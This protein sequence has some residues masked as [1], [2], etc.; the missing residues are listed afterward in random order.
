MASHR[1]PS[2]DCHG[3]RGDAEGAVAGP[4]A[5][6]APHQ[7]SSSSRANS[8]AS[9]GT[10]SSAVSPM[11]MDFTGTF[12]ASW[13]RPRHRLSRCHFDLV[14]TSPSPGPRPQRLT[15]SDR[16]L[17]DRR[18]ENEQ[19]SRAA[20]PVHRLPMTPYDFFISF[21]QRGAG[22]RRPADRLSTTSTP[23]ARRLSRASTLP[24]RGRGPGGAGRRTAPP[25]ARPHLAADP[26]A[27]LETCPPAA[28]RTRRPS[29][30]NARRQL[31]E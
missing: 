7:V 2:R 16:V 29:R 1:R 28:M 31:A 25:S 23:D 24:R 19:R 27:P 6:G 9:N 18:I 3:T 13:T 26:T 30:R 5:V 14:T 4:P 21:H 22:M 17:D 8:A 10:R 20:R 12:S 15:L 11:P